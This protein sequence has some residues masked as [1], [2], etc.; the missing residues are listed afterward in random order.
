MKSGF[1]SCTVMKRALASPVTNFYL[2]T[3]GP[4]GIVFDGDVSN[5]RVEL[6]PTGLEYKLRVM[7]RDTNAGI[8]V[9]ENVSGVVQ[10][11]T[12]LI[13]RSPMENTVDCI[14]ARDGLFRGIFSVRVTINEDIADFGSRS[15]FLTHA[16]KSFPN[17]MICEGSNILASTPLDVICKSPPSNK[18]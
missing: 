7:L 17:E 3:I 12:G 11:S 8:T 1:Y 9:C 14:P 18:Y 2:Y 16:M 13:N 5:G 10:P 6:E 4:A 15:V